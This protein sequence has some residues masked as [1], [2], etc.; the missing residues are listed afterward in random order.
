M[1]GTSDLAG[2]HQQVVWPLGFQ[3]LSCACVCVCVYVDGS[4]IPLPPSPPMRVTDATIAGTSP[5][6][7]KHRGQNLSRPYNL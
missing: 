6:K 3:V 7:V 2:T 1:V 4:F 5:L